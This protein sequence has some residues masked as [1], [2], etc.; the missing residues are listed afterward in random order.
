MAESQ[1]AQLNFKSNSY[2]VCSSYTA[3]PVNRDT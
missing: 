2:S 1:L 3:K